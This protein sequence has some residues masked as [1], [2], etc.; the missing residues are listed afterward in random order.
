MTSDSDRNPQGQDNADWL[1]ATHESAVPV[2][3]SPILSALT[4]STDIN[5]NQITP[6]E[7]TSD[8]DF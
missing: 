6:P 2:G 1:G 3:Q 5:G 7:E 4:S 8:G